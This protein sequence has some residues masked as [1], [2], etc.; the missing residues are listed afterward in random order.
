[1]V[2]HA[3]EMEVLEVRLGGSKGQIGVWVLACGLQVLCSLCKRRLEL[4]WVR[5]EG[6]HQARGLCLSQ[7]MLLEAAPAPAAAAWFQLSQTKLRHF[8][9]TVH[10]SHATPFQGRSP[11]G[12]TR[13]S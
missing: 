5:G 8:P 10:E 7:P 2:L 3:A 11:R 6:Q 4:I 13:S 1:M 12:P 9:S